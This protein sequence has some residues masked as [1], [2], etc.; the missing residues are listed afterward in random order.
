[1]S[2]DQVSLFFAKIDFLYT[3]EKTGEVVGASY[4]QQQNS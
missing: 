3:V 1:M 2:T 4:D